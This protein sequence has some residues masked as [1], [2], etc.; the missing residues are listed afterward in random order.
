MD[1][2]ECESPQRNFVT[3][4]AC[5][6]SIEINGFNVNM[7]LFSGIGPRIDENL[8]WFSCSGLDFTW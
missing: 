3:Q 6:I 5:L 8:L 7:E 2:N 4:L 1:R